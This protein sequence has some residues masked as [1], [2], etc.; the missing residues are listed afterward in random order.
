MPGV[1]GGSWEFLGG[2]GSSWA[3]SGDPGSSWEFMEV[4][5]GPYGKRNISMVFGWVTKGKY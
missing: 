2:P 3:V 1:S 4:L 5:G